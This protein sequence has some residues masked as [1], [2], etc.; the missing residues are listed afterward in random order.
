[1][2]CCAWPPGAQALTGGAAVAALNAQRAANGIPG[3]LIERREWSA[4]CTAHNRY[5]Q[6]NNVFDTVEDAHRR[7]YTNIGA[8][9]GAHSVLDWGTW[10][11]GRNP[12]ENAPLGLMPLLSPRLSQLG[13]SSSY[14]H[15]CATTT[16][17]YLRP[18]PSSPS[19]YSYPGDGAAA[20]PYKHWAYGLPVTPGDF[21]GLPAGF[22]TGPNLYV[23]ADVAG[24]AR[25][26]DAS[27][28]GPDGPVAIATVDNT[29]DRL[30]PYLPTGG[31]IIP[32]VPLE[33]G[34]TYRASATLT[35]G[36]ATLTR[37]WS[38]A[39]ELAD[40]YTLL[41][42]ASSL[43]FDPSTRPPTITQGSISVKTVSP[44]PV[45]VTVTSAG[46]TV[47]GRDLANGERWT[48]PQ[49]P[50]TFAVCAHQDAT[51]RYRGY[52][53]CR[54]LQIRDAASF[55]H[56]TTITLK[57]AIVGRTVRYKLIV[58]PARRREVTLSA[59]RLVNGRWHTFRTVVRDANRV[60][61]RSITARTSDAA[62]QILVTVPQVRVGPELYASARLVKTIRR[63]G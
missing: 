34:A 44:A 10:A 39:T 5:M 18:A 27:L 63:G 16:P 17:G 9:A 29:V 41:F 55:R 46:Q 58:S 56:P 28:V 53:A 37:G 11:A 35:V 2:A 52:D 7:G 54:P 22:T 62:V 15:V 8:W 13:I 51:D 47:A 57:A 23:M 49:T 50:G 33:S 30:G 48:P 38:F 36:G 14:H 6:L 25:I 12:W 4:A 61:T 40:P 60:L 1:M 43:S 21:V 59:R 3:D 19:L 32:V 26:T 31:M 20:V 42:V 24:E 45:H